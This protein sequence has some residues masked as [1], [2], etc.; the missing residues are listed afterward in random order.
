MET[1]KAR[2]T[3]NKQNP[4][5]KAHTSVGPRKLHNHKDPA[6]HDFWYPLLLGLNSRM[7]DP[8]V[9]SRSQKVGTFFLTPKQTKEGKPA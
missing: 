1:E 7:Q 5:T 8:I 4:E 6:R 2:K 9:C 3:P